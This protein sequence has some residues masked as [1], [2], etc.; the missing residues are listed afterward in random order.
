MFWKSGPRLATRIVLRLQAHRIH[1]S[2]FVLSQLARVLESH[3]YSELLITVVSS[4]PIKQLSYRRDSACW[5]SLRRSRSFKVTVNT[6]A[7]AL[8]IMQQ[9]VASPGTE[10]IGRTATVTFLPLKNVG[11]GEWNSEVFVR[12]IYIFT[13]PS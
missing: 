11:G 8:T 12:S 7:H 3:S 10:A 13:S 2:Q 9:T 4:A 6:V 1:D 5:Q